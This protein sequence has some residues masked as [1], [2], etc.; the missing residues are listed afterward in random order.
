MKKTM[1]IV[2]DSQDSLEYFKVIYGKYYKIES[3][4]DSKQA[5]H[6][7]LTNHQNVDVISVDLKMPGIDGIEFAGFVRTYSKCPIIM[8]TG[9]A[10]RK[11]VIKATKA[12]GIDLLISKIDTKAIENAAKKY[13]GEI[14]PK[15]VWYTIGRGS[16]ITVECSMS[17]NVPVSNDA[18]TVEIYKSFR[19]AIQ[20]AISNCIIGRNQYSSNIRRLK[21]IRKGKLV[22]AI[23]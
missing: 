1:L 22:K 4:L 8:V 10:T 7:L 18:R 15:I 20:S 11:D 5:L 13:S 17:N 14:K 6:W 12:A 19:E 9:D 2:D 3:Y 23:K 21:A 16:N